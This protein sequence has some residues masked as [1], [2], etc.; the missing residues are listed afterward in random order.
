MEKMELELELETIELPELAPEPAAKAETFEAALARFVETMSQYRK[1]HYAKHTPNL[2]D[3]N[4][5]QL[6]IDPNGQRYVR[7]FIRSYSGGRSVY[8]FVEKAT[9][10]VFKASSWKSQAQHP[11]GTIYTQDFKSYGCGLYGAEYLRR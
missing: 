1:A 10:L 3:T 4:E 8:C 6:H 9:G 5:W 7:I 11:R 2:L